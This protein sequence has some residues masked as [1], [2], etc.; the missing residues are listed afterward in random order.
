[1]AGDGNVT[2]FNPCTIEELSE[3]IGN[4]RPVFCSSDK[5][6]VGRPMS[7]G[8]MAYKGE[9]LEGTVIHRDQLNKVIEFQV[10]NQVVTVEAG[11]SLRSL[12]DA[13]AEHGQCLP[14][15]REGN[16]DIPSR[17]LLHELI[18][19][20]LPHSYSAQHG[21]WRD[22][23]AGMTLVLADGTIAKS[24][25]KVVK[26]VS[27]YDLHKLMIG[28]RGTLGIIAE[29]TLR[30]LPLGSL[31]KANLETRM[32]AK[33]WID[34][35]TYQRVLCTDW[36]KLCFWVRKSSPQYSLDHDARQ[37]LYELPDG[38]VPP[39]FDSEVF[40]SQVPDI[41]PEIPPAHQK[42]MHRAKQVFDPRSKLNPGE[43]G[44]L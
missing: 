22:W 6:L 26:S 16:F 25:S 19:F 31:A 13:L 2:T 33:E 12:N 34:R 14:F 32:E 35:K 8:L 41:A 10:E 24:G 30:T 43:F 42:L 39:R 28:G 36:E 9:G 17:V 1:M 3:A 11:I 7:P 15:G 29:V 23:V 21:S 5:N 20:D 44:F 38:V 4:S 18:E 27:G 40:W 37:A